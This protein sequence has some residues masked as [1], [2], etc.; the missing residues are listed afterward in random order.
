VC[1]QT[2]GVLLRECLHCSV[3]VLKE[4]LLLEARVHVALVL[5]VAVA[6]ALYRDKWIKSGK[7]QNA[8][9]LSLLR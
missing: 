5:P 8:P 4:H 3:K 2:A 6:L 9:F 1:A 7:S